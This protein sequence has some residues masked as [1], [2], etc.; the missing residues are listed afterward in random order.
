MAIFLRHPLSFIFVPS[1]DNKKP[2]QLKSTIRDLMHP[3]VDAPFFKTESVTDL[4]LEIRK[5]SGGCSMVWHSYWYFG[6]L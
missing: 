2:E 5:A 4:G 1:C 6:T 3:R